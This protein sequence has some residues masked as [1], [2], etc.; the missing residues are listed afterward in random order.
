MFSA[1]KYTPGVKG[2]Y[3]LTGCV[4]FMLMP[5]QA[6]II[7]SVY[8]NGVVFKNVSH[9]RADSGASSNNIGVN[10]SFQVDVDTVSDYFE[11]YV[12]QSTS[13]TKDVSGSEADTYFQGH[14]I[15]KS[16]KS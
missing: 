11:I 5:G 1:D 12:T 16:E 13:A 15:A 8:K 6:L 4:T 3:Q 7:V 10:F 2:K 9:Q 14:L